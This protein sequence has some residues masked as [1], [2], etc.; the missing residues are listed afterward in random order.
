M[1]A[2]KLARAAYLGIILVATTTLVCCSRGDLAFT[3][4]FQDAKGL[5]AGDPIVSAGTVIGRV[6][7]I[8]R[9]PE[10]G[11][12][13]Q[14]RVD[15]AH[16]GSVER[17]ARFVVENVTSTSGRAGGRQ[18]TV[19]APDAGAHTPIAD[20]DVVE[21]SEGTFRDLWRALNRAGSSAARAA[22]RLADEVS[23]AVKDASESPEAH[24][25]EQSLEELTREAERLGRQ[26]WD[27]L[28][29]HL[30]ELDEQVHRLGEEL[31]KA[32]KSEEAQKLRRQFERWSREV[33][34]RASRQDDHD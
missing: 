33:E 23:Q 10:G 32:G 20:G 15:R 16:R 31:D 29:R 22:R 2:A 13:V 19:H 17:E 34:R 8:D 27:D 7:A 9:A 4:T 18:I 26:G 3:I 12:R 14:V 25:L 6:T 28:R 1:D 30:P 21:G 11:V 5:V 24:D